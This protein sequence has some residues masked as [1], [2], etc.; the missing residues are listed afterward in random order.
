LR[1]ITEINVFI[2]RFMCVFV[3]VAAAATVEAGK[4]AFFVVVDRSIVYESFPSHPP[5]F[6]RSL[7]FC[8]A[9]IMEAFRKNQSIIGLQTKQPTTTTN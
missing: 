2:I 4:S 8:V 7:A 5:P 3:V 6:T 9:E 1:N